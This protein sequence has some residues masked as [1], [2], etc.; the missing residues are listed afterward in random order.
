MSLRVLEWDQ[1]DELW[2]GWTQLRVAGGLGCALR[3]STGDKR[4]C[5]LE[6]TGN[7]LFFLSNSLSVS[8]VRDSL[9]PQSC[10]RDGVFPGNSFL[11]LQ[12]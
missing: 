12:R 10:Q 5:T 2:A 6:N 4:Y 9:S 7:R 11:A 1:W 8:L 3:T